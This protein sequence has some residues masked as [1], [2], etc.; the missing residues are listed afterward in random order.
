M[1]YD[2]LSKGKQ[3][4]H[5]AHLHGARDDRATRENA[6]RRSVCYCEPRADGSGTI[7]CDNFVIFPYLDDVR[8]GDGG[9]FFYPGSHHASFVRPPTLF[10][11]YSQ[12][13]RSRHA[14]LPA[15]EQMI[16]NSELPDALPFGCIKPVSQRFPLDTHSP[17]CKIHTVYLW[18]VLQGGVCIYDRKR[19]R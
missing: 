10:G 1:L 18:R 9:V 16:E 11:K 19:L 7:G 12:E 5:G 3:H 15:A 2:D 4:A 13:D 14:A 8:E 17:P 6:V